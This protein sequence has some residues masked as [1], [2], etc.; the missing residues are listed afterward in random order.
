VTKKTFILGVGSS[1]S[2]TTWLHEYLSAAPG[3]YG[4][5]AKEYHVWDAVFVPECANFR[6]S[7]EQSFYADEYRLT[8]MMQNVKGYYH[9]YF[10]FLL[11]MPGINTTMDVTPPYSALDVDVLKFIR[12]GFQEL[13]IDVKVVFLM[14]EPVDRCWSMMRML[15]RK[16]NKA[17]TV[18]SS[19]DLLGHAR[20]RDC[21]IRGRYEAIVSRLE[22]VFAAEKIYLGIYEDMFSP[23]KIEALSSFIGV[24]TNHG[25]VQNKFNT[26]ERIGSI[27]PAARKEIEG[28]YSATYDFVYQRFPHV[29]QL[30][31]HG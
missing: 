22:Q 29:K 21:E 7:M 8:W 14:R 24:P 16:M 31:A 2:G 26:T 23:E 9:K 17:D 1:K 12:D 30:W 5:P 11:Q 28:L 15:Y 13:D 3:V 19:A 25:F 4:G 27:D 10:E 6:I 20:S 18:V